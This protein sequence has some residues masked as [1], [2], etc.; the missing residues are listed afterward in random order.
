MK[1]YYYKFNPVYQYVFIMFNKGY[2]LVTK[3]KIK[4]KEWYSTMF[5]LYILYCDR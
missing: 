1:Y 5:L 3:Y 2:F 4:L